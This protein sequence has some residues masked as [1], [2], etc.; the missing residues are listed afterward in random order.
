MWVLGKKI[1]RCTFLEF[2]M[3]LNFSMGKKC[4]S[5]IPN[6]MVL[7]EVEELLSVTQTNAFIIPLKHV[8][9]QMGHHQLICV[10]KL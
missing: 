5:H 1:E 2:K 7:M 10:Y 6:T 4:V 9:V 8:S 3:H